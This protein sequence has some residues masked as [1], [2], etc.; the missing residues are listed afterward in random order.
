MPEIDEA[1][2]LVCLFGLLLIHR[3]SQ[4]VEMILVI[5]FKVCSDLAVGVPARDVLHHQVGSGLLTV[6]NLLQIYWSTIILADVGD[7]TV[8]RVTFSG[9]RLVERTRG[10]WVDIS[11]LVVVTATAVATYCAQQYVVDLRSWEVVMNFKPASVR[12]PLEARRWWNMGSN[13]IRGIVVLMPIPAINI[14]QMLL[15]VIA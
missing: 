10:N 2:S 8:L 14:F 6:Q 9:L 4:V 5:L 12:D 11:C 15:I 7:E 1:I 3:Q 13:L